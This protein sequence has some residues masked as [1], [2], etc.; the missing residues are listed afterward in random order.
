MNDRAWLMF[1]DYF[2][3]GVKAT[4]PKAIVYVKTDAPWDGN[5]QIKSARALIDQ[6]CDVFYPVGE[7]T[8]VYDFLRSSSSSGKQ[9]L[10][11]GGDFPREAYPGLIITGAT[12]DWSVAFDRILLALHEGR[13]VPPDTYMKF[14]D[15][16]SLFDGP[17]QS[18]DPKFADI[19]RSKKIKTPDLG[20]INAY[21]LVMRRVDQL[22]RF[23]FEP[24]TGPIKD[25]KGKLRLGPGEIP[26][27]AF[28]DSLDWLVDNVKGEFSK[29]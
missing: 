16:I 28:W 14:E 1:A 6:G 15:G 17:R 13:E 2:A 8:Q 19:L 21:D 10:T 5:K 3:L 23:Q 9:I 24:F 27:P 20:E 26:D 12:Y 7:I 11:I 25:Q 22:R 18:I 29:R 4:N